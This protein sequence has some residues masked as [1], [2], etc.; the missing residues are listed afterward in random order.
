MQGGT[1]TGGSDGEI[2]CV[3]KGKGDCKRYG[4][5]YA[6]GASLSLRTLKNQGKMLTI[7]YVMQ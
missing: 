2:R 1:F 7:R 4:G 6:R 5:G 3:D